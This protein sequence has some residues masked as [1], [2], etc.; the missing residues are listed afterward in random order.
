M[1]SGYAREYCA[2]ALLMRRMEEATA[3]SNGAT[4]WP[5]AER[6]R[7]AYLQLDARNWLRRELKRRDG[8]TAELPSI[9]NA[10][11]AGNA[12]DSMGASWVVAVAPGGAH[13]KARGGAR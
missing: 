8:L 10:E 3:D 11:L 9:A 13:Q 2:S 4:N 1:D 6:C 12:A 5:N 7:M